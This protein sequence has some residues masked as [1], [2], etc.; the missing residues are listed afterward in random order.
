MRFWKLGVSGLLSL[1]LLIT[2]LSL[3]AVGGIVAGSSSAYAQTPVIRTIKV[4]GNRRVEPE[5]VRSYLRFSSGDRY[6]PLKVNESIKALF[7]TGLFSD[8]RIAI[9]GNQI[10][11]KIVENPII[12]QV[13]FEGNSEITDETL[14][15]EVQLKSRSIYTRARVQADVQRI[16]SVYRQGGRYA[17]RVEPK[18]IEKEQN[19]IDLV[20][21]IYEGPKTTVRNINFVGNYSFTESE[22]REV[23]TTTKT[24]LLSFLRPTNIYDPDRLNLDREL[25]RQ[26]YLKNGYADARILSATA[27]LDRAGRGCLITFTLEE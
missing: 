1:L 16:L 24:G 7:S 3:V 14:T 17:T 19:R 18:I 15:S 5:T 4:E 11:V 20:F 2:L 12:H 9:A 6:N 10:I 22:L 27:D 25:L 26:Y 21:E 13:A 8:V 23:I